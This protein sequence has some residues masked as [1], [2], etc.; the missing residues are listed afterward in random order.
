MTQ[1]LITVCMVSYRT[2]SHHYFN[3]TAFP[4]ARIDTPAEFPS[5]AVINENFRLTCSGSGDPEPAYTWY[6]ED[7]NGKD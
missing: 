7:E 3:T 1:T 2:C 4:T 5:T 6:L